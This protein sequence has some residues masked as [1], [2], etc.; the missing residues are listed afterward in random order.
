MWGVAASQHA[1]VQLARLEILSHR[2]VVSGETMGES[3]MLPR[4]ARNTPILAAQTHTTF[5][6]R[7]PSTFAGRYAP[8]AEAIASEPTR[9]SGPV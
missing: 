3:Q 9:H 4:T 7:P 1:S 8:F 6:A 5:L 2:V